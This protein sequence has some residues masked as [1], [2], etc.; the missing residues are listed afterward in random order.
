MSGLTVI[1]TPPAD[2]TVIVAPIATLAGGFGGYW[3][4][5]RNEE[6]RDRRASEREAEARNDA[7]SECLEDERHTFQ[8]DTLLHLQDELQHLLRV[9]ARD[10]HEHQRAVLAEGQLSTEPVP[11]D[12][13]L[14]R[15]SVTRLQARVLDDELRAAV[16]DFSARC[17]KAA[18]S[19]AIGAEVPSGGVPE[20]ER[21]H[22]VAQ[23]QRQAVEVVQAYAQLTRPLGDALRRELDRRCL[24]EAMPADAPGRSR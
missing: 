13:L 6:A 10:L 21:R 4:A 19:A 2:W 5:G 18:V 20:Q 9:T 1:V 7:R 17:S 16:E 8:R 15:A 11:D 23:L 24:A 3:L 12:E 14:I 22:V